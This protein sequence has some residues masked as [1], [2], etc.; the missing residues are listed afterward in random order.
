MK[1]FHLVFYIIFILALIFV[2]CVH[3]ISLPPLVHLEPTPHGILI[4]KVTLFNG[5]PEDAIQTKVDILIKRGKVL[6]IGK[7]ISEPGPIKRI[8]GNGKI[9]IPGLIDTHVHI[10]SPGA[11]PSMTVLPNP[12]RTLTQFLFAGVTTIFDTG[13]PLK[14]LHEVSQKLDSGKILGPRFFYSGE[15]FTKRNGHPVPLIK[16]LAPW[17]I[18]IFLIRESVFQIQEKSKISKQIQKNKK[19]GAKFTKIVVDRIPLDAPTLDEGDIRKIVRASKKVKFPVLA[20]IGTEQD[21][22]TA[23]KGGVTHFIHGPYRSAISDETIRMMKENEVIMAPTVNVF[24]N[25]SLFYQRELVFYDLDKKIADPEILE[26]YQHQKVKGTDRQFLNWALDMNKFMEQK[27]E[28]VKKMKKAGIPLIAGSDSA[29]VGSVAG[30]SL[31]RELELL[32][33]KCNFT[34][35][36]A[37][38]A[39]TYLPGKLFQE[40]TGIRDLGHVVEGGPADLVILNGDFREDIRNTTKINMVISKGMIVKREVF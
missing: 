17:P 6:K 27:F 1:K 14:S 32:V 4:K 39:A 37:V 7:N 22:Q 16:Y 31:H 10:H 28:N 30:S 19:F 13:G 36:E 34:P 15:L 35:I 20:H 5:N 12:E 8:D 38:S 33:E 9:A 18:E 11:P 25:I 23:M 21:I 2:Q 26:G 24:N 40:M 3:R 29:N